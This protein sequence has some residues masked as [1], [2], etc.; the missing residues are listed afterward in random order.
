MT[1]MK[2]L[3]D[4]YV[5]CEA[6]EKFQEWTKDYKKFSLGVHPA[7]KLDGKLNGEV[8]PLFWTVR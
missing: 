4:N 8:V 1:D 7:L 3:T 6:G 2:V 5:E